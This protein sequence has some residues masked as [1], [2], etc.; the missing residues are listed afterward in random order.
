MKKTFILIVIVLTG[1]VFAQNR[2]CSEILNP[3]ECYDMGCEWITLYEEI[4]NELIVTE[5]CFEPDD[6]YDDCLMFEAEDECVGAGCNWDDQ[7]GCFGSNDNEEDEGPPNCM[8]DCPDINNVDDISGTEFCYWLLEIFPTGC[9]E[10]CDQEVLDLIEEYMIACDECLSDNNCDE[11]FDDDNEDGCFEDGEWYCFGC[12]LFINECEY[13]ECTEDG[14]I[15][16]FE[17]DDCSDNNWSCSDIN[18]LYECYAMDCEWIAGNMPGA[19]SCIDG[20]GNDDCNPDLACA[21]V[22]TCEDG[23]LYPTSCGP[24]NCDE[25]IGYC[26]ENNEGCQSDDGEW[27]DFGSEMFVNQCEYYECTEN[28][29][30]GPFFLDAEDCSDVENPECEYLGYE[31]CM[32]FDYC[33]WISNNDNPVGGYCADVEGGHDDGPPDCL[34]DCEGI[35]YINPDENPYET[36]DWLISNFGPNNFFNECAYDCNDEVMMDIYSFVEG[37]YEC[38]ENEDVDCSEVFDD[39]NEYNCEELNYADCIESEICEWVVVNNWG[40]YACVEIQF[41]DSC[42]DL[43]FEECLQSPNCQPNYNATG[44]FENCEEFNSQQDWGVLYGR[45]EYIY[46]DVIDFVPYTTLYIESL[47]SNADMYFF[48]VMT[49]AEGYYYIELPVGPYLVTASVNNYSITQDAQVVPNSEFELNFLLGDWGGGFDSYAVLNLEDSQIAPE[50][51]AA[52]PLYL[53]SNEFVGG[54]Q[55]TLNMD[56]VDVVFLEEMESSDPCFS[57]NFNAVDDGT[58]GILFSLEGCSYPPEEMLHIADLIF[59]NSSYLSGSYVDLF[60]TSTIVSDANGVEVPSYGNGA[61]IMIG[62][63]GD[64][65][66]DAEVNVLD[67]VMVVNF[68][69]FIEE[70]TESQF[71]SADMN[72]DGMI[73]VLDIVA[74]INAILE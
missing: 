67:V 35:E 53:S 23:L 6:W 50:S 10:D 17:L 4:G 68:A 66:G 30:S 31:D 70:P 43:D 34:N 72:A 26:D 15:G 2:D 16:P 47:P 44:Q 42:S 3:D 12:E 54:V 7:E 5:G 63:Q 37:C 52:I 49:D 69:L 64:V 38:L 18:N 13:L 33:E 36:C 74:I 65:N 11:A 20:S 41:E 55:F 39:T 25:P 24:D 21:T 32:F 51:L 29:W 58:I 62:V 73:N 40:G 46:G 71:W 22:L 14:W 45:V 48:E 59:W 60:F 28:G 61:T 56:P 27:Y 9:A 8:M 1:F 19:G 57:A